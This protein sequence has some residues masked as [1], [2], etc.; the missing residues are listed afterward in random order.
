MVLPHWM[1]HS[2]ALVLFSQAALSADS[3]RPVEV[4]RLSGNPISRAYLLYSVAGESGIG[5]AKLKQGP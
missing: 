3:A 5:I 2:L 1:T 4:R